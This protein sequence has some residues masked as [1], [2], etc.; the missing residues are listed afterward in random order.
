MQ[1]I[2][3]LVLSSTIIGGFYTMNKIKKDINYQTS[4]SSRFDVKKP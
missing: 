1:L 4:Y 2:P 3:G